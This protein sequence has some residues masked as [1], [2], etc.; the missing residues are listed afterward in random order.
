MTVWGVYELQYNT[1]IIHY[2]H[3]STCFRDR[4]CNLVWRS[5]R[6]RQEAP[7]FSRRWPERSGTADSGCAAEVRQWTGSHRPPA[8][9]RERWA[10]PECGLSLCEQ[11]SRWW[12]PWNSRCGRPQNSIPFALSHCKFPPWHFTGRASVFTGHGGSILTVLW[13]AARLQSAEQDFSQGPPRDVL[14]RE[15]ESCFSE[16]DVRRLTAA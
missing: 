1:L 13:V 4:W 16:S 9:G 11:R 15:R 12:P 2:T 10:P 3:R 5:C 14:Q 7:L 8:R 6:E